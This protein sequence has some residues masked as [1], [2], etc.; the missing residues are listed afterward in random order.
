[1]CKIKDKS[2]HNTSFKSNNLPKKVWILALSFLILYT[3]DANC[4]SF[5]ASD[6]SKSKT[7]PN[8][9]FR[10]S[11]DAIE[12]IIEYKAKD[13]VYFD[14][15]AKKAY[16]YGNAE[17]KY[18]GLTL[19]SALIIVDF[20]RRELLAKG[21]IDSIGR[22][23]DKPHFDDGERQTDADT[24]VYNFE[25]KRGRTYG[26]IM[27]EG[28]GYIHSEKILR[29]EDKSIYGVDNKYTTCSNPHPHFHISASR[30][31]IIPDNKVV[32]GPS[33]LVI[34]DV[35]TP[36][37]VPFG[38]F[39]TKK[40]QKSGITP[41]EYG[42]S[43][44]YGPY[45]RNIG[46]YFAISEKFDQTINGD[47]YFRGSFRLA[48]NS[49]YAKKYK[50]N[51][52]LGLEY[53]KFL[54]GER[55]D[56]NF[57]SNSTKSFSIRWDHRQDAKARPGTT[58]NANVN[59][60]KNNFAQLNSL[61]PTQI[62]N[63][64]FT[65]SVTYSKMLLRNKVNLSVNAM[66]SQNTQTKDFS[67]TL[68]SL[69]LNVQRI[70]PFSKPNK[71]GKYSPF[72]DFGISYQGSLDNRINVKDSLFFTLEPI[73][74]L[75]LGEESILPTKLK[76][77]ES[78]RQGILHS[79]PI[80]LGSYKF[81][82]NHFSFTPS[83]SYQEY[84]YF[85]TIEKNWNSTK[86]KIDTTYIN[87]FSRAYEYGTSG[88][89][90]TQIFGTYQFNKKKIK[91]LRHTITPNIG[92]AYRPDFSA[93]KF[94]FYS[95]SIQ[96]DT[97]G[98]KAIYSKFEQGIKGL[99]GRG[100]QGLINYSIANSIQAKML[101]KTDSVP[102]YENKMLLENLS[103]NGNYNF[104]AD[105]F[106]LS[107]LTFSA[108]TRLFNLVSLNASA[109]VNPYQKIGNRYIDK[110]EILKGKRLG[111]TTSA[112]IQTATRINEAMFVKK[113]KSD[114][115]Y[116][117]KNEMESGELRAMMMDPYGYVNF[118]SNW[119][120]DFNYSI[121]Y[122]LN[123]YKSRYTHNLSAGGSFNLT[124]K[125]K[126]GCRSGYDF[127][128]K[129]ISYTQIDISR[130]LHCWALNFSWIPDGI[131]KSFTFSLY[132]NSSMLQ[133]LKVNKRRFWYDN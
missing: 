39:P 24:M 108:F 56:P 20:D 132:A 126:V 86:K 10:I 128:Q 68:P 112:Y 5:V 116:K 4:Q 91:A 50:H 131:R 124:P 77:H 78:F 29:D 57:K 125:W 119:D 114:T 19:N 76:S 51:G 87:G 31:K 47:A 115:A 12:S 102:I 28:E 32:F 61:N 6:S 8:D 52:T 9:T 109:T 35:P 21:R 45:L 101:K 99:P 27:K 100:K 2:L 73:K 110:L 89:I 111:A 79:F 71:K 46:Y 14:I 81:F 49:R 26:I 88:N 1:M 83:V 93:K 130:S 70:T 55:E 105:S 123:N 33:N 122:S 98:R 30:I 23:V 22:Y 17:V 74:K 85:E 16:L 69:N 25:S 120:L 118:N 36:L 129:K 41:F 34:E 121:N 67:L 97:L 58:F 7:I 75:V 133:S 103:L 15:K 90:G 80:T 94:D 117:P 104:L 92:I 37:Y 64:I 96:V 43:G 72:K 11:K 63:N 107:N 38:I 48:S 106:K 127:E 53:S 113:K 40:G 18:D 3:F 54:N 42:M 62:V 59:I 66:H 60:Q 44:A 95:D 65:S 84:W 13:S 82:K